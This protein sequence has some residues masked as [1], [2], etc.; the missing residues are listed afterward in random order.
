MCRHHNRAAFDYTKSY[1]DFQKKFKI[2][3]AAILDHH[4]L[5]AQSKIQCFHCIPG[6]RKPRYRHHNHA[7]TGPFHGKSSQVEKNKLSNSAM[8][9]SI[10]YFCIAYLICSKNCLRMQ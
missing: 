8:K 9:T 6:M 5:S 1:I 10:Y 7:S 3:V 2:L 4:Y